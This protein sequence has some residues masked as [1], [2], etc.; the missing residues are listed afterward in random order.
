[1]LVPDKEVHCI[2]CHKTSGAFKQTADNRWGHVVCALFI[3][4]LSFSNT[5]YME[6]IDG[7]ENIPSAR[8]NLV[9]PGITLILRNREQSCFLCKEKGACIQCVHS[10]CFTAFHVTCGKVAGLLTMHG[11]KG[12]CDKH[13]TVGNFAYNLGLSYRRKP[14]VGKALRPH[15]K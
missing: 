9:Q 5:V 1:M 15:R 2:F 7:V 11:L 3:F 10:G 14:Y 12:Y 4:E 13:M 6:P 8:W